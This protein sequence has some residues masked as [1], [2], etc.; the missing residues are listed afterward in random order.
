MIC[1]QNYTKYLETTST[2]DFVLRHEQIKFEFEKIPS[3]FDVHF[4]IKLLR[5]LST[6]FQAMMKP[7]SLAVK[8]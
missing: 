3:T 4:S 6:L 7:E 1:V 2:I 8:S 5:T